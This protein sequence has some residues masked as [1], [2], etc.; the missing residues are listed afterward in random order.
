MHYG[1]QQEPS[2]YTM[3]NNNETLVLE[4]TTEEKDLGVL[5][6]PSLKFSKHVAATCK[7]GNQLVG[8]IRRPFKYL[9]KQMFTSLYKS[10]IRPHL[11]Y[12]GTVWNPILKGDRW[13][14]E[15]VQRRATKLLPEIK[16]LP[17]GERL[18]SLKLPTLVYRRLRG[19]MIQTFKILHGHE[20]IKVDQLFQLSTQSRTRGHSLKID[21]QRCRTALRNH[22]FNQRVVDTWNALPEEIISAKSINIFKGALDRHWAAHPNRYDF[23]A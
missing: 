5:F 3:T 12:A 1:R 7:K 21:K 2:S 16:D 18:R 10:L 9:D 13:Q 15:K 6:D 8:I 22:M 4:T 17:Y 14:I 19:D 20:D 23:L 11:E